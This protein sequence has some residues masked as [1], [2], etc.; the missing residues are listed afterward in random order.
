MHDLFHQCMYTT[1]NSTLEQDRLSRNDMQLKNPQLHQ[2]YNCKVE[3]LLQSAEFMVRAA[4][5]RLCSYHLSII[6][7]FQMGLVSA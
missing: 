3:Y 2:L 5:H 7:C 4:M 1:Q 6:V